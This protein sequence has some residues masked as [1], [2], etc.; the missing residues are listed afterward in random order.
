MIKE[1]MHFSPSKSNEYSPGILNMIKI[2]IIKDFYIGRIFYNKTFNNTYG[3][4]K[5]TTYIFNN[6]K[7]NT[8]WKIFL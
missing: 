2:F 4:K 3:V 6:K 8:R 7:M 1:I 5:S